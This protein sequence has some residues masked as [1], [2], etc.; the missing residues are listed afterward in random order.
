MIADNYATHRHPNVQK[1]LEK[2]PRFNTHFTPTSASWLNRVQSLFRDIPENR[3]R[4][5]VFRSMPE[6]VAD[7]DE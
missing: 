2:H 4:S 1:W 3:P 5:G 6:L 7:I